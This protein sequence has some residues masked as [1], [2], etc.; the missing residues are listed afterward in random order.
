MKPYDKSVPMP[1]APMKYLPD[2]QVDWG[3]MWET[4]CAP[5]YDGG[6]PHRETMLCADV[7]DDPEN[8]AYQAIVKELIRGIYAVSGLGAQPATPGW[9]AVTCD[10]AEMA[11]WL[12]E[13]IQFENVQ[14]NDKRKVLLVP[15]GESYTLKG[16]IK[17]V[18]T[19]IAKSTHYW[20][21]HVPDAVKQTLMVQMKMMWLVER[22]RNY[23]NRRMYVDN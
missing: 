17:N 7:P 6:P 23:F 5:A 14:V 8:P 19:V 9:I 18:V 1:A 2:G 20:R 21:D 15:V 3:N 10:S 12:C 13:F 11:Q 22:F 4:F 16:E